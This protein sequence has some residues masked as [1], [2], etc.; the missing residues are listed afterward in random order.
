MYLQIRYTKGLYLQ[1]LRY[2]PTLVRTNV[3]TFGYDV[4]IYSSIGQTTDTAK[5][6]RVNFRL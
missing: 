4:S 5:L 6:V 3:R 2:S 1:F